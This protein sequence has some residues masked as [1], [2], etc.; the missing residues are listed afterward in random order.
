MCPPELAARTYFSFLAGQQC[1][2]Q[3]MHGCDLVSYTVIHQ[4]VSLHG[5]AFI[6]DAS[7]KTES[8]FSDKVFD[9]ERC[10]SCISGP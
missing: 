2:Q 8:I 9:V 6:G 7:S 1:F 5:A 3:Q 4:Q 10:S